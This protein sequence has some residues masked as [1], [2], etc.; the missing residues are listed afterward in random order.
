MK[1]FVLLYI[2]LKKYE[3]DF[4]TLYEHILSNFLFMFIFQIFNIEYKKFNQFELVQN[5]INIYEKEKN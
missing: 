3:I 2:K 4:L 5:Q 1:K